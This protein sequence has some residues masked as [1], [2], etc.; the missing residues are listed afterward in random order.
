MAFKNVLNETGDLDQM[1][2][3]GL[4]NAASNSIVQW[5]VWGNSNRHGGQTI[6]PKLPHPPCHREQDYF[7]LDLGV[8]KTTVLIWSSPGLILLAPD[9]EEAKVQIILPFFCVATIIFIIFWDFWCFI[10][11]SFHHKCN[12]AQLLMINVVH[13]SCFTS[14][15]TT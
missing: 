9:V 1:I 11:F 3:E 14:C 6:S 5:W 12:E 2:V 15:Q 7:R 13:T 4:C 10:K 8:L